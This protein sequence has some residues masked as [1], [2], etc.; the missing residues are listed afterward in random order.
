MRGAEVKTARFEGSLL[1][2]SQLAKGV[3]LLRITDGQQVSHQ[4]FVKE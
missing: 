1:N 3:Y 4:R 2:V